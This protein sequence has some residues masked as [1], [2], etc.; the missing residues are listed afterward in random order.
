MLF[1]AYLIAVR[2]V[3]QERECWKLGPTQQGFL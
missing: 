2:L 1:K 3:G